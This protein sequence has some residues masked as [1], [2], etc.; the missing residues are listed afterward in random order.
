MFGGLAVLGFVVHEASYLC[1]HGWWGNYWCL[2]GHQ[3]RWVLGALVVTFGQAFVAGLG[4]H[5]LSGKT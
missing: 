1:Q 4:F 3:D 2:Q 5:L